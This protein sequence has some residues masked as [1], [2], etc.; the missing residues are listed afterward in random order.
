M[1]TR[2][3]FAAVT[4]LL[5]CGAVNGQSQD[6][7]HILEFIGMEHLLNGSSIALPD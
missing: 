4:A 2:F 6:A 7:S 5:L 3:L 1:K